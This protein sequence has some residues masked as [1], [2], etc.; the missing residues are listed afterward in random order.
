MPKTNFLFNRRGSPRFYEDEKQKA[1]M[2]S[3][4]NFK[5][6]KPDEKPQ[7]NPLYDE[8]PDIKIKPPAQPIVRKIS[9]VKT[10]KLEFEQL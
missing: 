6:P 4:G 10:G 9:N 7:Y 5:E 8:G 1:I 2:L 3:S